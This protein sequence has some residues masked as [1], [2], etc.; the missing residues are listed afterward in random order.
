MNQITVLPV[1]S[2]IRFG[3]TE[4]SRFLPLAGLDGAEQS[5]EGNTGSSGD[6]GYEFWPSPSDCVRE[7]AFY[8][9]DPRYTKR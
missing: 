5:A 3:Q 8:L 4:S 7:S 9:S 6:A 2:P 1:H